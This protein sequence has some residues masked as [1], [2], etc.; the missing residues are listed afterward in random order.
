MQDWTWLTGATDLLG[1][2]G[3]MFHNLLGLNPIALLFALMT[4]LLLI[5]G[6]HEVRIR[7][8][9][10]IQDFIRAFDQLAI[11]GKDNIATPAVIQ[12]IGATPAGQQAVVPD[13]A[14]DT[15]IRQN[16]SFE[17][18]KSKYTS[19]IEPKTLSGETP[20]SRLGESDQIDRIIE[21]VGTFG[22]PADKR[23]F[24]STIGFIIACYYGFNAL[25]ATI[26]C[27]FGAG[28]CA[29][30]VGQACVQAGAGKLGSYAQLQIIGSLAFIGAYIAAIRIFLRGLAVFDLSS[31]T[32]LRQ[33]GEMVASVAF[34][35]LVYRA[36]PDPFYQIGT[37]LGAGFTPPADG[38]I[39]WI[40]LAL[41]PL[42]GLL[43]QSVTKFLLMKMQS[44]VS[45]IKTSDDRFITVT[46]I[47]SL[48]IIDGIDFETRFRLEEC[49]IYDV[50]N[51]ATYNPI[52]L[53]IESPFG[54]YQVI[55]WIAQAQLC[56]I[57]GP[58]KFLLFR[59]INIRTIFD[60][61]RAISDIASPPEFDEIC[62]SILFTNTDNLKQ[63]VAISKTK[64]TVVADG[65]AKDVDL[66]EYSRWI[67]E[68]IDN[69]NVSTATEHV[70]RWIADDLHVRRLRRLWKEI[71]TSLGDGSE[72]LD[73]GK[74]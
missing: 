38:S 27:G 56:H 63:T 17:F 60:L 2:I 58:E 14:A 39:P 21:S 42:F 44:M 70:M 43:P 61:E 18:V 36:F 13:P 46:K 19:D 41:A 53:H 23:I 68:K 4:P 45:W 55:D 9:R 52:M 47:V 15:P 74:L 57:V 50:Q 1:L 64:F 72:R 25:Q 32:F 3:D 28:G 16:P 71:S 40:W 66:A 51:L 33:T 37:A 54:I 6:R 48:D 24:F 30:S 11:R 26:L 49:G 7:R 12:D 65:V 22:S 34:T 69:T 67:R 62:V 8:L 59:E 73:N 5:Y 31:F 29:C 35:M 20:F 10:S